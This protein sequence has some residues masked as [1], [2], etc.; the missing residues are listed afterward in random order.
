MTIANVT[1]TSLD[2]T[3]LTFEKSTAVTAVQTAVYTH[4]RD[5][6]VCNSTVVSMCAFSNITYSQWLDGTVLLNP[7]PGQVVTD[8]SYQRNYP[9]SLYTQLPIA[10]ELSYWSQKSVLALTL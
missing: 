5:I 2:A 7:L 8:N 4:Y 9:Y 6:G 10:P 1:S 3:M